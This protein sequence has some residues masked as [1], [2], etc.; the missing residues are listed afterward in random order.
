MI[1]VLPDSGLGDI[2]CALPAVDELAK[3]NKVYLVV[4]NHIARGLIGWGGNILHPGDPPYWREN[5][6][7]VALSIHICVGKWGKPDHPVRLYYRQAEL[8]MPDGIP[9]PRIVIGGALPTFDFVVAPW[10]HDGE[11]RGLS[12]GRA[13]E[14][15]RLLRTAYPSSSIAVVGAPDSPRL[16]NDCITEYYGEDL[17]NIAGLIQNAR[18]AVITVD[19]F[20]NRLA[21]ATGTDK[22]VLLCAEVVPEIWGSH[23]KAHTLYGRATWTNENILRKIEE[24]Q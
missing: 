19:S 3:T 12:V 15:V 21:H 11:G 8:P 9:Q 6:T 24:C 20:P 1:V 4:F 7:S 18:K 5:E 13:E 16:S 17:R 22:H 23:P 10:S 14:L 2:V